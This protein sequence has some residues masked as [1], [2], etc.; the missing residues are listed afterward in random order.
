MTLFE[1]MA[2]SDSDLVDHKSV[3]DQKVVINDAQALHLVYSR[4]SHTAG[5]NSSGT[6]KKSWSKEVART[7]FAGA[8]PHRA[9]DLFVALRSF[10]IWLVRVLSSCS[11][12]IKS[13]KAQL[14]LVVKEK[15]TLP[16]TPLLVFERPSV[17]KAARC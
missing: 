12:F 2:I 3:S 16:E 15:N 1:L 7:A 4:P 11:I 14:G 6:I 13:F 9:E 5:L 8:P 17:V 10:S